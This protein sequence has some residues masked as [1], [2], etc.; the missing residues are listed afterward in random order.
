M[1]TRQLMGD[2]AGVHRIRG[3]NNDA[4]PVSHCASLDE[5]VGLLAGD[6]LCSSRDAAPLFDMGLDPGQRGGRGGGR[7][8]I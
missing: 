7:R 6:P 1:T 4:M 5:A 3:D 8:A 2:V